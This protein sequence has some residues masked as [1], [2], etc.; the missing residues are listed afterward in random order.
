MGLVSRWFSLIALQSEFKPIIP[1]A[2]A[3]IAYAVGCMIANKNL[4]EG[5][6]SN[7]TFYFRRPIESMIFCP[8]PKSIPRE[9]ALKKE[10]IIDVKEHL[11][12]YLLTI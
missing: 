10:N 9:F 6:Y 12:R 11:V 1:I 5:V 4:V 8:L 3:I 2:F 7:G